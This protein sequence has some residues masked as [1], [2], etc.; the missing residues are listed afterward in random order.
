M[1]L[2]LYLTTSTP[3]PHKGTGVYV[4]ENG[5]NVELQTLEEVREHFPDADLDAITEQ[6]TETNYLFDRNI[7]HNL[8]RMAD[9]V[10]CGDYT[11]YDLL[12]RPDE[13]GFTH[14]T[15]EYR[16][17]V[18]SALPYFLANRADL[19]QYNPSNGWGSYDSLLDFLF[20]Y[21]KALSQWDGIE[22]VE[23]TASR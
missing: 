22:K 19:E 7:T 21:C 6:T 5:A 15:N 13:H 4:R 14:V 12:W 18:N 3:R 17:L 9:K 10:P 20:E 16:S 11:L 8:T 2:D 1:S 23:I